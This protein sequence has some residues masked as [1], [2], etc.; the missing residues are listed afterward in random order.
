MV[1]PSS[2]V[3]TKVAAYPYFPT[4]ASSS[5]SIR[6]VAYPME[7]RRNTLRTATAP[8]VT[9]REWPHARSGNGSFYWFLANARSGAARQ[10]YV[11]CPAS[12]EEDEIVLD[13]RLG[14]EAGK[15]GFV[16][17]PD[18]RQRVVHFLGNARNRILIDRVLITI[19]RIGHDVTPHEMKCSW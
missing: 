1:S 12:S 6:Q 15:L 3:P 13:P 2:N 11:A 19:D 4:S 9:H 14:L 18:D 7:R 5:T 10:Q 8:A 17:P 16:D